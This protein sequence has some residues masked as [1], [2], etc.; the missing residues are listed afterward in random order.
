M[1]DRGGRAK[2]AAA[3]TDGVGV[4]GSNASTSQSRAGEWAG[5]QLDREGERISTLTL[6][7]TCRD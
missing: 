7:R 6:S 3:M 4:V 1:E 2:A 5:W